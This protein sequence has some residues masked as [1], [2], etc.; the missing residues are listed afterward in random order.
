MSQNSALMP[1][2]LELRQLKGAKPVENENTRG[3][4][5]KYSIRLSI[6]SHRKKVEI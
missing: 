1:K 4:G 3:S 5:Q 6:H 2:Q